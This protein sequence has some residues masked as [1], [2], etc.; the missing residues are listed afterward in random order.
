MGDISKG[1]A[2]TLKPAKNYTKKNIFNNKAGD[3]GPEPD[4]DSLVRGTDQ[5]PSLSS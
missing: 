4:P 3:P 5:D 2:N 1:V